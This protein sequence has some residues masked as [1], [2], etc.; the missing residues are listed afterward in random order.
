MTE[1]TNAAHKTPVVRI[2]TGRLIRASLPAVGLGAVGF[3]LLFAIIGVCTWT[4]GRLESSMVTIMVGGGPKYILFTMGIILLST[5]FGM[6]VAV[7]VTRR[8]IVTAILIATVVAVTV[9]AVLVLVCYFVERA[10]YSAGGVMATLEDPYP[11]ATLGQVPYLFLQNWFVF[12]GHLISGFLV[13]AGFLRLRGVGG[14]LFLLPA[15]LPAVIAE[16]AF[17]APWVGMGLN[18]LLGF[19]TPPLPIATAIA[20]VVSL[21]GTGAL[22]GLTRSAAVTPG[23]ANLD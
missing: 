17:G 21:A 15:L 22:Y 7:G 19:P 12:F 14:T 6:Y 10:L 8:Q 20:A 9:I 5:Q 2:I 11:M 18:V 23:S 16:M 3:V 1:M 13:V 4:F